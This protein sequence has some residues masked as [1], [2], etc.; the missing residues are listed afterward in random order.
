MKKKELIKIKGKV[1]FTY[2]DAKTGKIKRVEEYNNL[3]TT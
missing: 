1:K 2:R 3:V